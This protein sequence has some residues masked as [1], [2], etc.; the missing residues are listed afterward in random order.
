MWMYLGYAA[1]D[2]A[3]ERAR[4]ARDAAYQW[5]LAHAADADCAGRAAEAGLRPARR[6]RRAPPVQRRLAL[7]GRSGLRC[8][9]APRAPDGVTSLHQP[10]W[11]P[12]NDIAAVSWG[13]DRI[14]LF[15]VEADRV[16]WHRAF[17]GRWLEPES[18]GGSLASPPAV[19]AWAVDR[20][21]V[22][23]VFDDGELWDRY[24]DGESWH[25]W[26][27][28]GGSLAP[29]PRRPPAR[30]ATTGWTC[31]PPGLTG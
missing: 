2:L 13:P 28:L 16:L 20:M 4:E 14:D 9:V 30:G 5:Q 17:D 21:E 22:F 12:M 24:W 6:G 26:E 7:G 1:L 15:W 3:N 25:P 29:G 18:L 23:A 27:S 19:T 11:R 8:R 31:S 10:R